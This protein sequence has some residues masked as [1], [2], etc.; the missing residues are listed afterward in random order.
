MSVIFDVIQPAKKNEEP[1]KQEKYQLQNDMQ[2]KKE[3]FA[4]KQEND[5]NY[6]NKDEKQ[7]VTIWISFWKINPVRQFKS[8]F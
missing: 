4:E 2:D 7:E 5:Q 6:N 3:N 1:I 8:L